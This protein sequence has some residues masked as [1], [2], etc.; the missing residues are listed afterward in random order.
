MNIGKIFQDSS[1]ILHAFESYCV[2]QGAASLLLASL[3]KE[4]ELLRIFLHVSQMENTLLRRMNL[5]SFLMV[6]VQRVTKYPLLLSRLYKVTPIQ[7]ESRILLREAQHKVELHLN[8]I[9]SETKD[10]PSK[11]WRRISNGSSRALSSEMDLINIKLRKIAVDVLE[12]N[13]EEA[14]FVLESRLFFT[15]PTDHH[16]RK[17]RMIKLASVYALL[18]TN[19]RVS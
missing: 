1:Q 16:W 5:N 14:Q 7:H 12:W 18:V 9:N 11:L 19:G 15:Q 3:E 17:G 10:V 2:R 6:P 13:H 8:H 4:K